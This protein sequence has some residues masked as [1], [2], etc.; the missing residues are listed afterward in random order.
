[1]WRN[2]FTLDNSYSRTSANSTDPS[3][4]VPGYIQTGGS[5]ISDLRT[6]ERDWTWKTVLQ[7][8][9]QVWTLG[10]NVSRSTA[11]YDELPNPGGQYIFGGW[12]AYFAALSGGATATQLIARGYGRGT[13]AATAAAPFIQARVLRFRNSVV[14]AGARADYQSGAG[15]A[16]SPR[17][18]AVGLLRGFILRG[19]SGIFVDNWQASTLARILVQDGVNLQQFLSFDVPL[20]GSGSADINP[21]KSLIARLGSNF[22]RPERMQSKASIQRPLGSFIPGIEY[23]WTRGTHLLGSRRLDLP[24]EWVGLLESDRNLRK[25][26]IQSQMQYRRGRHSIIVNYRWIHSRDDTDGPFSF[27]EFQNNLIA[28][29]ARSTGVPAHN[30][31]IIGNFRLPASISMTAID[32]WHSASPFTVLTGFDVEG[33]GLFNDRGALP[34]NS[35]DIPRYTS[36]SLS[37]HRRIE[38]PVLPGSKKKIGADLGLRIDNL[39]DNRNYTAVGSVIGSPLFGKPLAALPG[40]ALRLWINVGR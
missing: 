35:G 2:G 23:T 1:M 34:R 16:F 7:P 18:S 21:G 10:T 8:N 36:A 5:P 14:M 30:V 6:S 20:L 19:G 28:E 38:V 13:Y 27:P 17:L 40:R 25:H 3:L 31:S 32:E 9:S 24:G 37:F 15:I 4:D 11:D 29:W 26:E 33:D 39:L 22:V 12:D